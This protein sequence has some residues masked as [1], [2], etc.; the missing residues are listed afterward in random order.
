M[1]ISAEFSGVMRWS[2]TGS[3]IG[4]L[5]MAVSL[6]WSRT[7]LAGRASGC[8]PGGRIP[9]SRSRQNQPEYERTDHIASGHTHADDRQPDADRCGGDDRS[10]LF[11]TA[12][13]DQTPV[14]ARQFEWH[15]RDGRDRLSATPPTLERGFR[16]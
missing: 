10:R 8:Q 13:A 2:A 1:T 15:S 7:D 12:S 9:S 5:V 11:L 4:R 14:V 3:R 16:S 6:S